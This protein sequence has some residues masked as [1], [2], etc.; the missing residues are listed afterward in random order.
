LERRD[1]YLKTFHLFPPKGCRI[2]L[3]KLLS[4]K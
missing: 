1:K 4:L 2:M 3:P